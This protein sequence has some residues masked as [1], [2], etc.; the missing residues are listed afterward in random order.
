[1]S[2]PLAGATAASGLTDA[3]VE[4]PEVESALPPPPPPGEP[5]L[6]MQGLKK[7]FPLTQGIVFRKTVGHVRAVDG[8]DLTLRRG[9]TLGLVGESGCGKST[10]SKLL[11]AL[12]KPTDGTILYKGRDV[13]RMGGRALKQYRREVQIIFQDPYASLNPR[14]TAGRHR[15]RGLV[16]ARGHRTA[17]GP[18]QADPGTAG[19]GRPQ[20]RFRQP[21]P[22]PVLRRPAAAHR[23]RPRAGTAAGDHRLRRAGVRARRLGAG[24]GGEP[25]RGPAGRL[26][27][28]LPLHRPRPVGRPAHQ[29]PRRR[30]VP[31]QRG[32]GGH[33]R[34]RLRLAVAPLHP[35]PAVLGAAARAPSA[36]PEGPHPAAGRRAQPGQPALGL[37][38]PHPLLEGPGHLRGRAPRR[39]STAGRATRRPATSP[40]PEPW[41]PPTR[42]RTAPRP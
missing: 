2:E 1:M 32:G 15:R 35:G 30:D 19:P 25:A 36:G 14:M 13:A 24:A 5:L 10:V 38:V 41:C 22:A 34:R 26:R 29:R 27:P 11:V 17:Q 18:A 16:G 42:A 6:V 20:P 7:Y 33:R 8:V 39:W 21:L 4:L 40:R 23:H 9:E 3:A 28:V 31:R 12:E 37:P